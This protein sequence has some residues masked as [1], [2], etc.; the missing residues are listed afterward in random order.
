MHLYI[1]KKFQKFYPQDPM[2][3]PTSHLVGMSQASLDGDSF[4]NLPYF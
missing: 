4:S 3:G 2:Q 1:K